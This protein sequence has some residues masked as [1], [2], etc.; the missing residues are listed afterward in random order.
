MTGNV[1]SL[2]E[3]F[4]GAD[5][6]FVIPVYQRNYDWK[7]ANCA[8]LFEDLLSLADSDRD[9]HFMGSIVSAAIDGKKSNLLIIDGQQRITTVSLLFLAMVK[10]MKKGLCSSVDPN[11]CQKIEEVYL[12]NKYRT[13]QRR[14]R[15]KPVKEDCEA[16]DRLFSEEEEDY[17]R[18]SNVTQNY[19][20][21]YE[22]IVKGHFSVDKLYDAIERLKVV[23][24]FLESK[25]DPQLI[26]ESLNSTGLSLQEGDKIRN[27]ILMSLEP[28]VQEVYYE[29]YWNKIEK[30]TEYNVSDFVRDYLTLQEGKIPALKQIY[31]SFKD[32]KK[33]K[34]IPT[35]P[36]LADLLKHSGNYL[37]IR[38]ASMPE[39]EVNVLLARLNQLEM[40]VTYPF[41]LALFDYR[42]GAAV[43]AD[44]I[45]DILHC[46]EVYIFR[47]LICGLPTNALNKIFSTLHNDV[48]RLKKET[49][50]YAEVL[51][52]VLTSKVASGAFP[53][54]ETFSAALADRNIYAMNPKNKGYLFERLENRD[55]KER[56]NVS[57]GM[58]KGIFSVEHIM[59]RTLTNQW[60]AEL[61]PQYQRIYNKWI[62]S[63]ANLTL[64]GYNSKYSNRPFKDKRDMAEGFKDSGL[65]LNKFVAACE[66]WTEAELQERNRLLQEQ[67]L[68]LWEYPVVSFVPQ[69]RRDETFGL[70]DDYD[71]TGKP[72]L[73]FSFR[74]TVNRVSSWKEMMIDVVKMIYEEQPA[75]INHLTD[76]SDFYDL[77]RVTDHYRSEIMPEVFLYTSSST[78]SKLETLRRI[79]TFCHLDYTLL[80]FQVRADQE[81]TDGG[82]L[83]V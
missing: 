20:Y 2:C 54:D 10:A 61:G 47:R 12:I 13:E 43:S 78:K 6:R 23:D 25:D 63:L 80:E 51:K 5:K 46:I 40:S 14:I 77:S 64:T 45:A 75:M 73:A 24:I 81:E 62:N 35:E 52:Y 82:V 8:Q 30:N 66:Q 69:R 38:R 48:L 21:F 36:L 27:Y 7:I 16:F 74:D 70:E 49:D 58:E 41:L 50:S 31:F 59:P 44:E 4:D 39:A 29:K 1:I 71:L 42:T 68:R 17:I 56:V 55:S 9:S 3:F 57:E 72:I 32:Y 18:S 22:R 65:R 11:L 60:K 34:E 83:Q 79:F 19:L 26:F 28:E 76:S 53:S 15:L 37:K 33:R 67:A